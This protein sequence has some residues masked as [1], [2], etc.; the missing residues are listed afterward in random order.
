MNT[1]FEG[2]QPGSFYLHT[3]AVIQEA[4]PDREAGWQRQQ[5]R[6]VMTVAFEERKRLVTGDDVGE[7]VPTYPRTPEELA[8]LEEDFRAGELAG[9]VQWRT[10]SSSS[11]RHDQRVEV[12]QA[13]GIICIRRGGS[14]TSAIYLTTPDWYV[15]A[16]DLESG[17]KLTQLAELRPE[18][19]MLLGEQF[20]PARRRELRDTIDA[21]LVSA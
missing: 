1:E 6:E 18:A 20:T 16:K 9:E 10:P 21:I 12:A 14:P 17:A 19:E 11:G 5:A 8:N 2:P 7:L 3:L 15:F 13:R 4:H